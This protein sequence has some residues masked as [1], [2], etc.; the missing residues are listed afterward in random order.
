MCP[1]FDR[2]H[3]DLYSLI[4]VIDL[5]LF[6]L[7]DDACFVTLCRIPCSGL[8]EGEIP[9]SMGQLTSLTMIIFSGNQ[10][11]GNKYWLISFPFSL[12]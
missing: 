8:G 12:L 3:E 7:Y 11:S 6:R 5:C 1:S 10:L 9:A 2:R 4:D